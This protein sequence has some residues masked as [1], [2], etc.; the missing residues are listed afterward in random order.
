MYKSGDNFDEGTV[1]RRIP[2][3][4]E[5]TVN[6]EKGRIEFEFIPDIDDQV[7]KFLNS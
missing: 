5:V 6:I 4:D 1:R 7:I 2:G 3:A